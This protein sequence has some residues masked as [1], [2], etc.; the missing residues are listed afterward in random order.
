MK[1]EFEYKEDNSRKFGTDLEYGEVCFIE[2]NNGLYMRTTAGGFVNLST[3]VITQLE[4]SQVY[5]RRVKTKLI[6]GE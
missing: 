3:G 5:V 6:V 4:P 1:I 2:A